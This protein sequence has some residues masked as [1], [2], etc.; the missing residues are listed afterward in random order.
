M[1]DFER[2]IS[3][4]QQGTTYSWD[5]TTLLGLGVAVPRSL[6]D[7][8]LGGRTTLDEE[9]EIRSIYARRLFLDVLPRARALARNVTQ[10]KG[11]RG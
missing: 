10:R 3:H 6:R 5:L 8:L 4:M 11:R 9:A 1:T 7:H 2:V